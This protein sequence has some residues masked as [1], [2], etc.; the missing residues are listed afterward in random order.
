MKPV[1]AM[2]GITIVMLL[3]GF[4][5]EIRSF[6]RR[7]EQDYLPTAPVSSPEAIAA[8]PTAAEAPRT[9]VESTELTQLRTEVAALKE[10]LANVK[11]RSSA[12]LAAVLGLKEADVTFILDRSEMLPNAMRL[13]EAL[14]A[15][16]PE[17]TW[18]ALQLEM[19]LYRDIAEFKTTHPIQNDDRVNWHHLQLT[20]WLTSQIASVC[21]RLYS[22]NMP[23][24]VVESFRSHLT[25]GI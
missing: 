12:D 7:V 20:P 10:R 2:L 1:I 3:V 13:R 8:K 24:S 21:E 11:P 23:S 17:A 15:V 25:E 14:D 19:K 22:L 16:G 6:K 4:T 9:L 18:G 5:S